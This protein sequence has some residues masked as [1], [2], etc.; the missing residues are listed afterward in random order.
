MLDPIDKVVEYVQLREKCN[1]AQSLVIHTD[2]PLEP[3]KPPPL[4]QPTVFPKDH[5][6][7]TSFVPHV[8]QNILKEHERVDFYDQGGVLVGTYEDG[9]LYHGEYIGDDEPIPLSFDWRKETLNGQPYIRLEVIDQGDCGS[10]YAVCG[11]NMLDDRISIATKGKIRVVTSIQDMINCGK[12][13][14]KEILRNGN[15]TPEIKRLFTEKIVEDADVYAL[16]GCNGGLLISTCA[17]MVI[18]GLPLQKDV[19][20][21]YNPNDPNPPNKANS[22]ASSYCTFRDKFPKYF[23]AR[24]GQLTHAEESGFPPYTVVYPPD[25]LEFNNKNMMASLVNFGPFIT[26]INIYTDFLYYPYLDDSSPK[27]NPTK[28]YIYR[29]RNSNFVVNNKSIKNVYEG[30]HAVLVVGYGETVDQTGNLIKYWIAK[31]SW[32]TNWGYGGYLFIERGTNQA[33]FEFDAAHVFPD[34]NKLGVMSTLFTSSTGNPT[35]DTLLIVFICSTIV[36]F[37]LF[38]IFSTLYAL[39][40]KRYSS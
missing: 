32:G 5:G 29:K 34:L 15:F 39:K 28:P 38:A 25:I 14:V 33:N 8:P 13:F 11:T 17:Y 3:I 23:A 21:L 7:I 4:R 9:V 19:P 10:C 26:G 36:F 31:N 37:I 24:S 30:A 6:P 18:A 16:E 35:T 40:K 1:Q 22:K 2:S 20:Y 27:V 12:D